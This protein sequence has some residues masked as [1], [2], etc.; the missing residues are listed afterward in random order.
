MTTAAHTLARAEGL[1]GDNRA[2]RA[3]ILVEALLRDEPGDLAGWLLL[4]RIRLALSDDEGALVAAGTAVGLSPGYGYPL[5]LVA[6]ALS[7]LDRQYDAVA[8]GLR[9][10]TCAPDDPFLHDIYARLV[11]TSDDDCLDEAERAARIAVS[12]APA[13]AEYHATL[14]VV[15]TLIGRHTEAQDALHA[16]LRLDPANDRA[17][18]HLDEAYR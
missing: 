6:M 7:G 16:A 10:V 3:E 12:L 2:D 17:R 9:A 8:A 11:I 4:A 13:D 1:L 18:L 15:L 5:I 14:G